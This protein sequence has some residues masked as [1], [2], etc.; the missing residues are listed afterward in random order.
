VLA[1]QNKD[2]IFLQLTCDAKSGWSDERDMPR[3]EVRRA[4][5]TAAC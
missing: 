3:A 5:D 1:T 2:G 4:V